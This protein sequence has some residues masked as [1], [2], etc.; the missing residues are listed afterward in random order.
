M[1]AGF[2]GKR[3]VS[4]VAVWVPATVGTRLRG[5]ELT[6]RREGRAGT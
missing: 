1:R 2:E 5:R 4:G 3:G 6:E